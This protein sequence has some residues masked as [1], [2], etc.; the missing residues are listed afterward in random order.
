VFSYADKEQNFRFNY[1]FELFF[2]SIF[3]LYWSWRKM[4]KWKDDLMVILTFFENE[5]LTD[6]KKKNFER[7]PRT[8]NR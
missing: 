4:E 5:K 3:E 6:F 2:N 1:E 8:N 7:I